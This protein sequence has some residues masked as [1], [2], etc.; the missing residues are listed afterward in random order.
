[1]AATANPGIPLP[2]NG[3]GTDAE[4]LAAQENFSANVHRFLAP[5]AGDYIGIRLASQQTANQKAAQAIDLLTQQISDPP[6]Q[7]EMAA[8]QAQINALHLMLRGGS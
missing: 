2:P 4:R 7:A 3:Q 8:L 5:E 6:T 1:M